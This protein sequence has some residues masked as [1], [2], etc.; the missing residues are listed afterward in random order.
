MR[1]FAAGSLLVA[2]VATAWSVGGALTAPGTL[3]PPIRMVEWVRSHGGG[4][5]VANAERVWYGLNA[6]S[7]GGRPAK[8]L[9]PTHHHRSS[10][11]S[12]PSVPHL[13]PPAPI[14]Q[15]P[16][17]HIAG[18]GTWQPIGFP[19]NG[20]YP[21][22]ASYV[23]PSPAY[24]SLVTGVVWID[25]KLVSA[26]LFAGSQSPGVG[27]WTYSSPLAGSTTTGLEA[28]FNAGF[29]MNASNGGWYSEGKTAV[30]LRNGA[31][32]FVIMKNGTASVGQWGRDFTMGPNIAS[33]RQNLSLIVDGGKPVPGLSNNNFQQWGLTL[34]NQLMVW[35][36]GVGVT[37]NG[38]LIYVGGP[39]LSITGLA[40][41]LVRAGAVRAMEFDINTDWVNFFY[42]SPPPGQPSSPLNGAKLLSDMIRPVNRYFTPTARDFVA[43]YARNSTAASGSGVSAASN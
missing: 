20:I 36:S 27:T 24:T 12:S 42:F 39:G 16:G 22:Y 41:T 19:V 34:G 31:A 18:E 23:A 3:S 13:Q 2:S 15:F 37:K 6:P 30:P 29:R 40:R 8:G 32:S 4:S 33:V 5:L 38:A 21:M 11:S 7:K 17:V 26:R 1:R 14:S 25:P 28:A 10:A 35:R 9:I 43:L